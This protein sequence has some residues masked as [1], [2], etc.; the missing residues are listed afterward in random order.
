MQSPSAFSGSC[1]T[2]ILLDLPRDLNINLVLISHC[3]KV[4]EVLQRKK[5]MAIK[6]KSSFNFQVVSVIRGAK[7]NVP[8]TELVV[9]D[10]I[11]L[12]VG[13]TVPADL[14]VIGADKCKVSNL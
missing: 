8:V 7:L 6:L 13:D 1:K 11:E 4:S 3:F 9:G 5:S 14:R 12:K 10:I 2:Q